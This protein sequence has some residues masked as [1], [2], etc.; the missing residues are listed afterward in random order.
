M[1]DSYRGMTWD[2][3]RGKDALIASEAVA[4]DRFG[5]DVSW[6][7]H[8][9][10]AFESA[11]IAAI[12]HQ[13]D[14]VVLDHPHVGDMVESGEFYSMEQ[15]LGA[16]TLTEYHRT[17]VGPSLESYQLDG[18]TWALPLDAA[19]QVS[20]VRTDLLDS[21]PETWADYVELAREASVAL[22][23]IGPHA[24]LSFLSLCGSL[25]AVSVNGF[26][27]SAPEREI[28]REAL[29]IMSGILQYQNSDTLELN[30]IAMLERM[31]ST[32]DIAAVPLIYGYSQ[33]AVHAS[34]PVT[35]GNAPIAHTQGVHGSIIGGT[36]L[37]VSK[38]ATLS[39]G[40]R[41]Y[42]LWLISEST[43]TEFIPD[44]HG[45]PA[46]VD[47]WM[48]AH[49]NAQ[50]ANFYSSTLRTL[51]QSQVRPRFR[52]YTA[53]QHLASTTIREGLLAGKSPDAI[54]DDIQSAFHPQPIPTGG[55]D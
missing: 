53:Q 31:V 39:D 54:L 8:P 22:S 27:S 18:V 15:V 47:A 36:G 34:R 9:L 45:Q 41:E 50:Y 13:N 52:G 6:D 3:P 37:A 26:W 49:V 16:E 30:P 48:S 24:F 14:L 12:T 7:A 38:R 44:H 20:A 10:E 5:V 46:R 1:T 42:I 11:P 21:R 4:R 40:L 23:V 25:D 28:G 32:D 33:Y 17:F 55:Q 19:A 2:H 51:E 29:S 43:Q 35:F